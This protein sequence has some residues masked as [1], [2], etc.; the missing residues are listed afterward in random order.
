MLNLDVSRPLRSHGQLR[1]LIEA[2]LVAGS[3]DEGEW[4]EWKTDVDLA[5]P[6][7]RGTIGRHV[8][9]FANRTPARAARWAA[10]CAYLLVG[11]EPDQLKGIQPVD[12]ADLDAQLRRFTAD[13]VD[14]SFQFVQVDGRH[15]LVVIVEPPRPGDPIHTL[16]SQF[17]KYQA[18]AI[19]IRRPGR[20][21]LAN[22]A[23]MDALQARLL[24]RTAQLQVALEL[25][26]QSML[27]PRLELGEKALQARLERERTARLTARGPHGLPLDTA[28]ELGVNALLG[29]QDTRTAED[30]R[31][32]VDKY[33]ARLH[34]QLAAR[35]CAS[36]F[37]QNLGRLDLVLVN[38]T[39]RNFAAVE[40][41]VTLPAAV[42]A[43]DEEPKHRMPTPPRPWKTPPPFQLLGGPWTTPF[44]IPP[45]KAP[46]WDVAIEPIEEGVE[47]RFAA[48][49]LRPHERAP[50][51]LVH[52][53]ARAD[54][55]VSDVVANWS[56][57][58]TASDGLQSGTLHVPVEDRV[59]P[60]DELLSWIDDDERAQDANEE[61][62]RA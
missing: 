4:V 62:E 23:E 53:F 43:L 60:L 17:G 40:I 49:D 19:F 44:V 9:G 26:Q 10:G 30:Y 13:Q 47:L 50:L 52:L 51:P 16:R 33:L 34:P 35:A 42:L 18:G 25:G 56:A 29:L 22:P 6:E 5:D 57:T 1:A 28:A 20:T 2:V 12:P 3:A 46:K 48:V 58:S 15:V 24:Q 7:G 21:D 61:Q 45:F 59:R 11:V 39:D 14:W 32:E 37:R 38:P 54:A 31:T 27:I 55:H 41:I 36:A 8:L